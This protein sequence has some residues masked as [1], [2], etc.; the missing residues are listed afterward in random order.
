MQNSNTVIKALVE[1]PDLEFKLPQI[2]GKDVWVPGVEGEFKHTS[3][4][5]V[6]H[7]IWAFNTSML[8]TSIDKSMQ[9]I[10]AWM[11]ESLKRV[12]PLVLIF[13]EVEN[14]M[15]SINSGIMFDIDGDG[16]KIERA[17]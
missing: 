9:E 17:G 11:T 2:D 10:S 14:S 12:D 7:K 8:T 3:I 16:K 4:D 6:M 1:Y 15:I 5:D 13:G